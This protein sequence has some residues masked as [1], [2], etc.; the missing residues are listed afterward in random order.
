MPSSW[1]WR[2]TVPVSRVDASGLPDHGTGVGAGGGRV[3]DE[4]RARRGAVWPEGQDRATAVDEVPARA[5]VHT[6]QGER[7]HE[8][9]GSVGHRH[10]WHRSHCWGRASPLAAQQVSGTPCSASATITIDGELGWLGTQQEEER[11]HESLEGAMSVVAGVTLLLAGML[12]GAPL[13]AQVVTGRQAHP[14]PRRPSRG[15]RSR[16]DSRHSAG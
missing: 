6:Q 13:T 4:I 10:W 5:R 1:S 11:E 14:V 2:P 15:A 8:A 12:F 3:R 7:S 9:S 16:W